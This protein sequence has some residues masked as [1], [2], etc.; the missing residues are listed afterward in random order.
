VLI[1][2]TQTCRSLYIRLHYHL[3]MVSLAPLVPAEPAGVPHH[4]VLVLVLPQQLMQQ[5]IQPFNLLEVTEVRDVLQ[6]QQLAVAVAVLQVQMV[7]VVQAA[8]IPLLL[9]PQVVAVAVVMGVLQGQVL[10]P[11]LALL[12]PVPVQGVQEVLQVPLELQAEG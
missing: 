11:L 4:Q 8:Q 9:E 5:S 2:A 7:W 1:K 6:L 12:E 10:Q 3:L